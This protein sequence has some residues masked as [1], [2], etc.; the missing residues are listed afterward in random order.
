MTKRRINL[1]LAVED[2][3]HIIG[4]DD[5][6]ETVLENLI[7]NALSFTPDDGWIGVS[8]QASGEIVT[9]VI[10]DSGPGVPESDHALIFERYFS[11]RDEVEHTRHHAEDDHL[12]IGLWIVRTHLS[13][14][15]GTIRAETGN[16]GGLRLIVTLPLD[17]SHT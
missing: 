8:L 17:L 2:Q 9:M 5:L 3:I 15:G 14:I 1:Q 16:R 13:A 6:F 4:S 7:D 11:R 12:G 10:E